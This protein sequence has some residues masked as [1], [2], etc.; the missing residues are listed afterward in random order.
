[1]DGLGL[2]VFASWFSPADA[3]LRRQVE[4]GKLLVEREGATLDRYDA[5][6]L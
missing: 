2:T 5:R 1:M 6:N 3:N 4:S